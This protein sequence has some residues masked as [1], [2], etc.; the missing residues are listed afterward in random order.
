MDALRQ[1]ENPVVRD[2]AWA[3]FSEDLILADALA[4]RPQALYACS[5]SDL[6]PARLAWL[7]ALDRAPQPLLDHV[8]PRVGQRL[9]LYFESLWH[10]FLRCDPTVELLSHNLPVRDAGR[11]VG[12]FDCLYRCHDSGDIV[13]LE[14]AVKFYLHTGAGSGGTGDD[15][16]DWLGPGRRDRLDHKLTHLAGHQTRLAE[17]PAAQRLLKSRSMV[18]E[19]V[20]VAVKGRL[21]CRPDQPCLPPTGFNPARSL[22]Q[23]DYV[24]AL[25]GVAGDENIGPGHRIL[26][27]HQWLAPLGLSQDLPSEA[28]PAPLYIGTAALQDALRERFAAGS[29]PLLVAS[30]DAAHCECQRF[31][32]APPGWPD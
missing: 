15:R 22:L 28:S 29:G 5:L 18:P 32:I 11:T 14:L 2:L 26:P 8:G 25:T 6:T 31:F 30:L 19:R 23:W 12:E 1:L 10:F 21:F 4:P 16:A 9:G 13:H 17:H 20:E 7:K 24:D 27:R 3:V